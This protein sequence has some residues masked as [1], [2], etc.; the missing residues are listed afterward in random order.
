MGSIGDTLIGIAAIVVGI[1]GIILVQGNIKGEDNAP[2]RI[3]LNLVFA[4]ILLIGIVVIISIAGNILPSITP[5]PTP[6][7]QE[8]WA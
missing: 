7:W 1:L 3:G 2:L 6:E 4:L 8:Q 5:T